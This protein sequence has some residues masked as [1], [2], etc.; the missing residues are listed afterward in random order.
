M[1]YFFPGKLST[2]E[3]PA[4]NKKELLRLISLFIIS[5]LALLINPNH[6]HTYQYAYGLTHSK[7]IYELG[8]FKS[9]FDPMYSSSIS[10]I[11]YKTFLVSGF[12]ILYYSFKKKDI[13]AF[14]LTAAFGLYS[15]KAT[16][17]TADYNII[18]V[19]CIFI[20][21]ASLSS[22]KFKE[23]FKFSYVPKI[24]LGILL[25]FQ[26]INIPNDTLFNEYL[27]YYRKWG[28]GTDKNFTSD[29]MFD[30]IRNNKLDGIGN[31]VFNSYTCGGYFIWSFPQSKNF[32]D[33]RF[34]NDEIYGEYDNIYY[35]KPGFKEK[36]NNYNI[37]YFILL[38]PGLI[39]NPQ[40]LGRSIAAYLSSMSSEWKQVYW[41]DNSFIFVKNIPKF[42]P[43]ISKYEYKYVTPFNFLYQKKVIDKAFTD[44][45]DEFIKEL[46]RNLSNEPDGFIINTIS[47]TYKI[48]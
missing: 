41:D 15:I 39:Q 5:I 17:F 27:K 26:L 11:L 43:I 45:K 18:A 13:L 20:G 14:L 7:F 16:R 25:L 33:S 24:I 29:G 30:F 37:D 2:K 3:I 1:I 12:F 40:V 48:R 34:I 36:L 28:T 31:H 10:E 32:I 44:D 22:N 35:M 8:E 19:L 46:R 4:L 6:I 42:E 47:N 9:P 38:I 21:I 23:T